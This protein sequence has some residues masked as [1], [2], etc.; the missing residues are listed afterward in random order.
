M[1]RI[2]GFLLL[3]FLTACSKDS[4]TPTPT[5]KPKFNITIVAG[6]GGSVSSSGGSYE[7][8]TTYSVTASAS[9]GYRF[10]GW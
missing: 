8:G 7:Q 3:V 9:N 10:T 5:P 1:K 4:E 2:L 6:E